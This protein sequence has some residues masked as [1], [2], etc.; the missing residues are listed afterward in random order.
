MHPAARARFCMAK[1]PRIRPVGWLVGWSGIDIDGRL[2]AA[3]EVLDDARIWKNMGGGGGALFS[4]CSYKL[5]RRCSHLNNGSRSDMKNQ[6]YLQSAVRL[7]VSFT[8]R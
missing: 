8:F 1:I 6:N 7:F 5:V 4:Y 3:F 2:N